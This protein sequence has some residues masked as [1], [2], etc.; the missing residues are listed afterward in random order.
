[1]MEAEEQ[2]GVGKGGKAG[3]TCFYRLLGD[4]KENE[5]DAP[6][7]KIVNILYQ[8]ESLTRQVLSGGGNMN[9]GGRKTRSRVHIP[10]SSRD[11]ER[12]MRKRKMA[13]KSQRQTFFSPTSTQDGTTKEFIAAGSH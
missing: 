11:T 1:M 7:A 3:A 2:G 5:N 13:A 8:N 10:P 6:R 4:R 9:P 12:E